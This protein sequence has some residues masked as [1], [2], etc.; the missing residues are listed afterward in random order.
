MV[1]RAAPGR[2]DLIPAGAAGGEEPAL[3]QWA[4]ELLTA[5]LP[6]QRAAVSGE[7][8][9]RRA[10]TT[11]STLSAGS[12]AQSAEAPTPLPPFFTK[13]RSSSAA[14]SMNASPSMKR[15]RARACRGA[16]GWRAARRPRA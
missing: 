14:R 10:T 12:A 7:A 15:R 11:A 1:T 5:P 16:Q 13:F 9:N 6:T 4:R 3:N 2:G 8:A